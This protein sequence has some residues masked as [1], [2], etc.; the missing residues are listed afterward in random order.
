MEIGVSRLPREVGRQAKDDKVGHFLERDLQQKSKVL[1]ASYHRLLTDDSGL[2]A[3]ATIAQ[4]SCIILH[5]KSPM[6]GILAMQQ[7]G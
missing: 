1:C 3:R 6:P 5:P 2:F 4:Q 7:H